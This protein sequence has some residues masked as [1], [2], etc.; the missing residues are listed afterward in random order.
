VCRQLIEEFPPFDAFAATLPRPYKSN[1]L[2]V[3]H[4]SRELNDPDLTPLWR[5][6]IATHVSQE[7]LD[8]LLRVFGDA[9][10]SRYPSFFDRIGS[11]DTLR[12][13]IR[14][15]DGFDSADI[16]LEAQTAINTPVTARPSAVREAHLD[17][18]N[19]LL[20]GLYYLRH[21]DDD[22]SGGDLELYRYATTEPRFDG[23]EVPMRF[24][25]PVKRVKYETN[26][27]LMFLNT[28]D[29]LHGVTVRGPTTWTR[30]FLNLST[31]VETDLFSIPSA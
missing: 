26:V 12:A 17:N 8:H 16:L 25:E 27:L 20:N 31:E 7:H 3:Y 30:R 10:R 1:E 19:K 22:S 9:I 24:V 5:E 14:H 23:H 18:P 15:V 13:G 21:P 4:A 2:L 6:M 28:F 11:A 29:S